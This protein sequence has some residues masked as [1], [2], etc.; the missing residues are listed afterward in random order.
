[1]NKDRYLGCL[2]GLAVGDAVGTTVE[3]SPRGTFPPVTDMVG[4]GPF[5]LRPGDW[6][7]DTSMAL[8]LAQSL[9]YRRAFDAADQMNRYCN[10]ANHGY[11]SSTG[12]CFDIGGTV[13]QALRRYQDSGEPFSG[14]TDPFSAGNGAIM[15]LAPVP[16][17]FAASLERSVYFSGES[18]RTTHA[19]PEAVECARLFGAQIRAALLGGD[20]STILGQ[21]GYAPKEPKVA[22]IAAVSYR[23]K[24]E[25]EVTGSGYVVKSLEAALWCFERSSSFHEA[26]LRAV[27][28]G[29]DADT[30]AAICGQLSGAY[31]GFKAIPVQWQKRLTMREEIV[32]LALQLYELKESQPSVAADR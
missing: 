16:M 12:E 7:D 14:S 21:A 4:G 26:V 15:R 32:H 22:G 20:K 1:M 19:A 25:A 28:L 5:G 9:I 8:C 6:T 10:W 27:N 31:Y 18:S 3:F 30:T 24:S 13:A 23:E 29:D 2:I 17:F 11:M